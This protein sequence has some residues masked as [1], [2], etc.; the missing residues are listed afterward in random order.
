MYVF[1]SAGSLS[2][3]AGSL[4]FQQAGATLHC[5]VCSVVVGASPVVEHGL[6]N[7]RAPV[8]VVHGLS[9]PS[10]CEISHAGIES[11]RSHMQ[12]SNPCPLHWQADS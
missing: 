11:M 2:L 3:L 10:A 5:R 12:G 4:Q 7:P 6:W 1:D 8:V 9:C